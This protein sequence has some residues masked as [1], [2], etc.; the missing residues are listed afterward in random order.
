MV[1]IRCRVVVGDI[2]YIPRTITRIL[3][4][5]RLQLRQRDVVRRF[6]PQLHVARSGLPWYPSGHYVFRFNDAR[7]LQFGLQP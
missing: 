4:W 1:L 3:R 7:R 6:L 2:S 5:W